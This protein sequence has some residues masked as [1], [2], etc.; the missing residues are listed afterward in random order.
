M[1]VAESSMWTIQRMSRSGSAHFL[2][3]RAGSAGLL[4]QAGSIDCGSELIVGWDGRG[5]RHDKMHS[6]AGTMWIT[7]RAQHTGNAPLLQ[8]WHPNA[9]SRSST[10]GT[11][12]TCLAILSTHKQIPR[13]A[14][15]VTA[16]SRDCWLYSSLRIR[17]VII[18]LL[19]NISEQLANR[20]AALQARNLDFGS[21]ATP[22]TATT[23]PVANAS[24][25]IP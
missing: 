6:S 25:G 19:C 8:P 14:H 21:D 10:L 2:R 24:P 15:V 20:M 12:S 7:T 13:G 17:L 5:G 9:S 18:G 1:T 11:V 22:A 4:C 23:G 16:C 3:Y